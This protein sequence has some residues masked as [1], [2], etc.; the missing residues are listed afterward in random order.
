L[1]VTIVIV[2]Q[3]SKKPNNQ[4]KSSILRAFSFKQPIVLSKTHKGF[5]NAYLRPDYDF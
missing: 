5:E 1:A 2:A 4:S 3:G